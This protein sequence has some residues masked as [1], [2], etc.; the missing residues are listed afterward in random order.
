[1]NTQMSQ[2]GQA[3]QRPRQPVP[4]SASQYAY[5]PDR[6][7]AGATAQETNAYIKDYALVA[8]AAKRAELAVL[9][10]E[11]ESLSWN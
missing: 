5:Q 11:M 4:V 1:M 8:E 7:N 2:Q 10:R 6:S 9:T 3:Q